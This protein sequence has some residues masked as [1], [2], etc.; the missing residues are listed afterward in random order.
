MLRNLDMREEEAV[1]KLCVEMRRRRILVRNQKGGKKYQAQSNEGK[2]MNIRKRFSIIFGT[3][4]FSMLAPR[5]NA[6]V[7]DHAARE[8]AQGSVR[9][10]L[11]YL[12]PGQFLSVQRDEGLERSLAVTA[13]GLAGMEFIYQVSPAGDEIK[14]HA[15]V[16]HLVTDA[17]SSYLVAVNPADGSTY[18][19][20]GFRDSKAELNRLLAALRIKVSSKDQSEEL[21]DFYRTVNPER[22]SMTR[23]SGLLDLKQAAERQCQAVPF[24]PN[25]RDFEAWWKHAKTAYSNVSFRQTATRS[26][27]GYAVE[28]IVLSS[29]GVGQCGGAPLRARLEVLSDGSIGEISFRPL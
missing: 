3:V 8:K 6:Q 5:A 24:D 29:A 19:I 7:T 23:I 13:G 17:D 10:Q 25:E 11:D 18:R 9:S 20:A 21:A 28:W 14:E 26:D 4:L 1:K 15:V 22:R 27:S 2:P 16:H 12:R